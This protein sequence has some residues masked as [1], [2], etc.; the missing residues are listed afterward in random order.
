MNQGAGRLLLESTI[1]RAR[2]IEGLEQ[3][4]LS[5]S[6]DSPSAI[7]LYGKTGFIRTGVLRRQIKIGDDYHD[8][9]TMWLLSLTRPELTWE[10][11]RLLCFARAN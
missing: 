8:F 6:S 10:A 11:N 1:E 7:H 9:I 3:L 4:E 5:V 2:E